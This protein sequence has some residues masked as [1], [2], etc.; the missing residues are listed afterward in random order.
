MLRSKPKAVVTAPPKQGHAVKA[1]EAT[2]VPEDDGEECLPPP[3]YQNTLGDALLYAVTTKKIKKKK[4]NKANQAA[5]L[6]LEID[7]D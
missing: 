4:A 7:D 3:A 2:R 5:K 6:S 1:A